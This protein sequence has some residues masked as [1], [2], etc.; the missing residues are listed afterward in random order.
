ML[1]SRKIQAQDPALPGDGLLML[2]Q[3]QSPAP[4]AESGHRT[5]KKMLRLLRT[6]LR[7]MVRGAL[8]LRALFALA[9][10]AVEIG[11]RN[12]LNRIPDIGDPFDVA[13]F[14]VFKVPDEQNAFT[15]LRR[16][17]KR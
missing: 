1:G 11:A 3:Q 14:R 15:F 4:A 10:G 6:R 8:A 2:T 5:S 17:T 16:H 12:S 13:A 9:A 7:Q